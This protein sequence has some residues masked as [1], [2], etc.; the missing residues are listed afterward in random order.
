MNT[1]TD[2]VGFIRYFKGVLI[3]QY[4]T[5]QTPIRYLAACCVSE[6]LRSQCIEFIVILECYGKAN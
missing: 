3:K 2:T 4:S 6:R 1:E 5:G